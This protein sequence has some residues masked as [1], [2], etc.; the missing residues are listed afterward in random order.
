[1]F[2]PE[3]PRHLTPGRP[4]RTRRL[5]SA[6]VLPL[7]LALALLATTS[8]ADADSFPVQAGGPT[9]TSMIEQ[10][11]PGARR[12][13]ARPGV[14]KALDSVLADSRVDHRM[15]A[16][17]IR[18]PHAAPYIGGAIR[19]LD[20]VRGIPGANLVVE[21]MA[22]ARDDAGPR[23]AALE[24]RVGAKLGSR[25]KSLSA[26]VGGHEVDAL[27]KDGTVVEVKSRKTTGRN[28]PGSSFHKAVKQL[29]LRSTGGANV[30]LATN[31]KLSPQFLGE[32]RS[33]F[34][35]SGRVFHVT[36]TS[37]HPTRPQT[38]VKPKPQ[39]EM[40]TKQ[41]RTRFRVYRPQ[42]HKGN[43]VKARHAGGQH[44][45]RAPVKARPAKAKSHGRFRGKT[46][47]VS[48]AR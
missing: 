12:A 11:P 8:R 24:L 26:T 34:G 4:A 47:A 30:M 13:L 43:G 45:Y 29:K 7:A 27:L 32:F 6:L 16:R 48:R 39:K 1:M 15:L 40:L 35:N 36:M 44:R 46:R 28:L 17:A 33:E 38:V 21:R 18:N 23:G 9:V 2:P 42:Q 22:T 5:S 31:G 19:S 20:R 3:P 37:P 10:A 25:L 41:A 14:R